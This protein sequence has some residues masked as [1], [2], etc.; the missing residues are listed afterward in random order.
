M[1]IDLDISNNISLLPAAGF[2]ERIWFAEQLEPGTG[3]YNVPMTWRVRPALRADALARALADVV[4]RHEILRTRFLDHTGVLG[5]VVGPPWTPVLRQEDLRGLHAEHRSHRLAELLEEDAGHTFDLSSGRPLTASLIRLADDEQVFSLCVHHLVWDAGSEEP[6]LDDLEHFYRRAATADAPDPAVAAPTATVRATPHQ[7]RMAFIDTFENGTVY[8]HP[9]VYHNQA[10]VHRLAEAPDP[11]LLDALATALFERHEV[12]RTRLVETPDGFVQRLAAAAPVTVDHLT[13]DSHELS[14]WLRR[15]FDLSTS[16]LLRIAVQSPPDGADGTAGTLLAIVGHQAVVDRTSLD[17]IIAELVAGLAKE[18]TPTRPADGYRSW[19]QRRDPD[20]AR[21]D[22]AFLAEPLRRTVEPLA[23]PLARPRAAIH[24]YEERSVTVELPAEERLSSFAG[25]D[26]TVEAV[27][28]AAFAA[29]LSWYSGQQDLVVGLTHDLRG[30]ADR[31]TVGPL[32]NLLPLRLE[33]PAHR[34]FHGWAGDVAAR[35][36]EVRA[37]GSAAFE[38]V[39]LDVVP[40]KD[41]S[42]TALFDVLFEYRRRAPHAGVAEL[43]TGEGKYDL[44]LFVESGPEGYSARL[45]YNGLYFDES[46]LRALAT[47]FTRLLEQAMGDTELPVDELEPL[48][49]NERRTQLERWNDTAA[50]YPDTTLHGLIRE[51]ALARPDAVAVTDGGHSVSYGELVA[52]AYAIARALAARGVRPGECVALFLDRGADQVRA[53]L[54]VLASGGAYLPLDPGAPAARTELIVEDSGTRWIIVNEPDARA[55]ARSLARTAEVLDLAELLRVGAQAAAPEPPATTPRETAYVIYTS[56]TTGCPKGVPITHRNVVRLLSNDRFSFDFGPGD[57]W[58]FFHSYAFDFSVWEVFGCL[59]HGGRLVVIGKEDAKDVSRFT[60]VVRREGVTVL[61]QTPSAFA[62]FIRHGREQSVPLP[63]LRYVIF[64]GEKLQP[65]MLADWHRLH[66]RA[67]LVN[68]YGITEITVHATVHR[69]TEEDIAGDVSNVGVPLPTNSLR[70]LDRRSGRRLLPVGAVGELYVGGE[71]VTPGYLG[72][73]EL[74]AQR[75]VLD[76]FGGGRLFRSGD[77][78]RYLPDGTLEFVG[79][80]DSQIKLRGYRIEPGEIEA[81]LSTHPAVAET[82]VLL[83][84]G[85]EGRLI[86]YVRLSGDRPASAALRGHLAER[87]PEY[88]LPS[89]FRTVPCF[90]LTVNGKVDLDALAGLGAPLDGPGEQGVQLTATATELAGI[91]RGLLN[92]DVLT[93]ASSFFEVGGHSL[94]ATRLV[95]QV[96]ERFGVRLRLREV[97]EYPTLQD[98]ADRVDT[99]RSA[100]GPATDAVLSDAEPASDFQRRAWLA[101]RGGD[102]GLYQ[103]HLVWRVHGPLERRTLAD[104]LALLVS[105]HE[106]LRTRFVEHLGRVHQ[107][108]GEEWAPEVV[109]EDATAYGPDGGERWATEWIRRE[110]GLPFDPASGRMLRAT[111]ARLSADEQIFALCVHHLA[112]DGESV[113]VLLRDLAACYAAV[114][115]ETTE[116]DRPTPVQYREFVRDRQARITAPAHDKLQ[117]RCVERLAGAPAYPALTPPTTA[118]PN[119]YVPLRLPADLLERLRPVQ[120]VHRT[121]WFTVVTTA[122][123]AVLHR[124]TGADDLTIGT[125]VAL[126]EGP[127]AANVIGPCLNTLVLRSRTADGTTLG[128]LLDGLRESVFDAMGGQDVPFDTLVE[129]LDPPQRPG[130]T[131]YADISVNVNAVPSSAAPLGDAVLEQLLP[132]DFW[133]HEAKLAMTLTLFSGNGPLRALLS[134]RGDRFRR[135]D[136]EHIAAELGELLAHFADRLA[137]PVRAAT[138]GTDA[139][140][141]LPPAV[142]YREYIDAQRTKAASREGRELVEW[143]AGKLAGAPAYPALGPVPAAEPHGIVTL[144]F[145]PDLLQK[146]RAVGTRHRTS[147]FTVVAAALAAV[148]HRWT[149]QDDLTIGTPVGNRGQDL[150]T[151]IGPCMN[152]VALRSGLPDDITLGGLLEQMRETVLD[153]LDRSDVAFEAV[154]ERLNPPRRPGMTPYLDVTLST[155]GSAPQREFAGAGLS[156]LSPVSEQAGEAVKYG[157][158]FGVRVT[159]DRIEGTLSYRGDRITAVDARRLARLLA[160]VLDRFRD[161]LDR[162]VRTLDLMDAE[163]R[164]TVAAYESGPTPYPA[165]TVPAMLARQLA[166]RPDAPAVETD[167]G[168]LNYADLVARAGALAEEL[169]PY[170]DGPHPVV[171]VLLDRGADYVV[172]MLAAWLAGCAYCPIDPAYP[173]DRI[174][175]VLGDLG[176]EVVVTDPTLGIDVSRLPVPHVDVTLARTCV[177]ILEIPVPDPSDIAYVLYTSG[178][179]GRPKGAAVTHG[180]LAQ[181]SLWKQEFLGLGPDDRVSHGVSVGFDVAQAEVWPALAS[182]AVLLPYEQ[183]LTPDGFA[184]WLDE[185]RISVAWAA[186][187]VAELIWALGHEL[188]RLRQLI[189]G[190][191]AITSLPATRPGYRILNAYGPTEATVFV[192]THQVD[193]DAPV[194]LSRIGVPVTGARLY[195]L[196]VEGRRCPAG[197][198]GEICI[199][200]TGLSAG[201]W[202]HP[203]LTA[204]AFRATD[205]D[206]RP[207]PVYRT[208]DLGRWLPDGT[209]DY[210]GR[211]DRQIKVRGHRVEPAEIEHHLRQTPGVAHCAVRAFPGKAAELVGYAVPRDGAILNTA[212]IL[213]ELRGRLPR[214]MVPDAILTLVELPHTAHGKVDY[215]ALPQPDRT[216]LVGEGPRELP[217]TELEQRIGSAWRA[218]LHT[219]QVG[220]HD[221][222]FD[223][224]GNSL[225]LAALHGRLR[226]ELKPD[227]PMHWLFEHPTVHA[228]ATALADTGPENGGRTSKRAAAARKSRAARTRPRKQNQEETS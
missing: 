141:T 91:W 156:P 16:P 78:A 21:R 89:T 49:E 195:V 185:R 88:M 183:P 20:R 220:V 103:V 94:M 164:D 159:G 76:P 190:G 201:Y 42:R 74:N 170:A 130:W 39:V 58:S 55:K 3:L 62:E 26:T 182:G 131:P 7:E 123:A 17:L 11:A 59:A 172:A 87:L 169:R 223:L 215:A 208:G 24:V 73:P 194:P 210:L 99:H 32:T 79:R 211:L 40:G 102:S 19:W 29:T 160:R 25:V 162:P 75:F 146:V 222:F 68:M 47:H 50:R 1:S 67:E 122:L 35:L 213:G 148:M 142:Q 72:Q 105:R 104:A 2:Q 125:P 77:L 179:T 180:G 189:V 38:D 23:L 132:E 227:L 92:V 53:M 177:D 69:L 153:T 52:D 36:S 81:A 5:Q 135:A 6:F 204:R 221:N 14:S 171:A 86:A 120:S 115:G 150:A 226:A 174:E 168:T 124:W 114:R 158:L 100:E 143:W 165:T 31:R 188:P 218:V 127:G 57:V 96:S 161:Q 107:V 184:N 206:G 30:D 85:S 147:W 193:V 98:L 18:P 4:E 205:P 176:T 121:T 192:G 84:G 8:P 66:P 46:Q 140:P 33:V 216:A 106:I 178:T 95:G 48:T 128:E 41:M 65:R 13:A 166:E 197:V 9:P 112:F 154:V 155:L 34:P 82:V 136:A 126:R 70:V 212:Q 117:E 60:D 51:A 15:P 186:T 228:M 144:P 198:P 10:A 43:V 22:L 44:H 202:R 97:F 152:T 214:F 83:E 199:G 61:N 139:Q 225:L 219:D 203:E 145:S 108:V 134:Y 113:P 12:L 129:R 109:A 200:G 181:L 207:E 118:E 45:L 209:L 175:Y 191:A 63:D 119:G 56:G 101:E 163:E 37:H 116:S 149:G 64:G 93:A 138:A 217:R 71:G 157:L 173:A 137:E 111:L 167:A 110:T 151:V 133:A 28:L 196:D 54:G 90:P 80:A 224:G 187:P 27:L